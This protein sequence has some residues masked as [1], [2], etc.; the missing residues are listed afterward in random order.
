MA[1]NGMKTYLF[2]FDGTLVDSMPVYAGVM[3]RILEEQ[4]I[5]YDDDIM[6]TIT[7]LGYAGTAKYFRRMGMSLP[8]E[9]IIATMLRYAVDAYTHR[10]PAKAYVTDVLR[11]LKARGD[12]LHILTA[13]PH[14]TLNPCLKRLG[15]ADLFMNVWSCEDF[16]TTKGDPD[17]YRQ[18][19][20]Q[21]GK[22]VDEIW[23]LDDNLN[24]VLTA[25]AAGMRVCGVY[26]ETS[27]EYTA[28]IKAACDAY[29]EDFSQLLDLC[30]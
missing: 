1:E 11:Q 2:D 28:R 29:I 15:I 4:G 5:A 23:F 10:V 14:A 25:K 20:Q 18:A 24:A 8:E 13:S 12:D 6:K 26:D 7:P 19:A 9:E 16:G 21:I 30:E 3:L 27:A 22:P 17:I